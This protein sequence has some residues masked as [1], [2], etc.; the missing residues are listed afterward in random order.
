MPEFRLYVP[1]LAMPLNMLLLAWMVIGR[2]L[3]VQ[4]GWVAPPRLPAE[5]TRPGTV[6]LTRSD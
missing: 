2:G 3:F 5:A 6:A 4:L 1:A